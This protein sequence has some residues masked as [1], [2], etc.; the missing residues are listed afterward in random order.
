MTMEDG[1]GWWWWCIFSRRPHNQTPGPLWRRQ[2]RKFVLNLQPGRNEPSRKKAPSSALVPR[3]TVRFP[4]TEFPATLTRHRRG[5]AAS[6]GHAGQGR[7]V[8][9]QVLCGAES[10]STARPGVSAALR[11]YK[12]VS[13]IL[14]YVTASRISLTCI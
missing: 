12:G 13:Y 6:Q 2:R 1:K 14:A 7:A 4:A 9:V 3:M 5:A 10:R 11:P 8:S